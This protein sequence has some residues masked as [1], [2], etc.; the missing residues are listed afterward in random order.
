M[1]HGLD[2]EKAVNSVVELAAF[3]FVLLVGLLL[4]VGLLRPLIARRRLIFC[5]T[6]INSA[7]EGDACSVLVLLNLVCYAQKNM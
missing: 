3:L 5:F 4:W 1:I 6:K 7:R 2:G